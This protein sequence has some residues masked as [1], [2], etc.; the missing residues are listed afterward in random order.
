MIGSKTN[1]HTS[2]THT[3]FRIY[4][5]LV[6]LDI[7]VKLYRAISGI[8]YVI[9][10]VNIVICNDPLCQVGRYRANIDMYFA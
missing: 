10:Y 6:G 7:G 8:K 2:N 5:M 4:Y 3:H 1:H 9:V